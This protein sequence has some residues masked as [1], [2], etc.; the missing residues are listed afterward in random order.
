[1]TSTD[2]P[3][4]I[5]TSGQSQGGGSSSN[6]GPIVGGVVGG[7]IALA[8][9][10]A[11]LL[12]ILKRKKSQE[13]FDDMFN[14]D[15]TLDRPTQMQSMDIAGSA[16]ATR[17][18]SPATTSQSYG[19]MS[20]QM[21]YPPTGAALYPV[22]GAQQG[23]YNTSP[24][25]TGHHPGGGPSNQPAYATGFQ[26]SYAPGQI[27][28]RPYSNMGYPPSQGPYGPES[29]AYGAAMISPNIYGPSG[30]STTSHNT[31]TTGSDAALLAGRYGP[32]PD[33][34]QAGT[35]SIATDPSVTSSGGGPRYDKQRELAAQRNQLRLVGENSA[36]PR[37]DAPV[38]VH[39]DGGRVPEPVAESPAPNE[40]PPT[41]ESINH[42][43]DS[44]S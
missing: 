2:V 27:V 11:I 17:P 28:Q 40:I 13:R 24:P 23:G 38:V 39:Q 44:R 19:D 31:G 20:S 36:E 14:P 26:P 3:V 42:E 29:S 33:R 9:L 15:H 34:Q 5:P 22:A 8:A 41:Y 12:Y 7:V 10:A 35:P 16:A 1:M 18:F 43:A 21:G 25:S 4:P 37:S 32:G 6:I 30:Q